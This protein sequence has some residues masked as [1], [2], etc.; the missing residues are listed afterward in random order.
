[1]RSPL[2]F[3]LEF[4]PI[5]VSLWCCIELLPEVSPVFIGAEAIVGEVTSTYASRPEVSPDMRPPLEFFVG[6]VPIEVPL[7]LEQTLPEISP[8]F[9]R[10][11]KATVGEVFVPP[12]SSLSGL[13]PSRS[14]FDALPNYYL[15]SFQAIVGEVSPSYASCPKM[16]LEI[17]P[18]HEWS[19][20]FIAIEVS[21]WRCNKLL[22][23]VAPVFVRTE[24][25][26]G[27]FSPTYSTPMS[28][29]SDLLPSSFLS[30]RLLVV[31]FVTLFTRMAAGCV[32]GVVEVRLSYHPV[33][34]QFAMQTN[35]WT[36]GM[37]GQNCGEEQVEVLGAMQLYRASHPPC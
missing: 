20:G 5:E 33:F 17:R 35:N 34:Y 30:G 8:V 29:L 36:C 24:D 1:M 25:I 4:V 3:S 22:P 16:P 28:S 15:S 37:C 9:V 19:L 2:E 21:L 27:E 11:Y 23:E 32:T 26:V 13:L 18:P 31:A 14:L 6:F 10:T 7:W 12:L